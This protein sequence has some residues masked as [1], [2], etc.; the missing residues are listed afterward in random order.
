MC[1]PTERS[2]WM[3]IPDEPTHLTQLVET[4]SEDQ[5]NLKTV[6]RVTVYP[7][8]SGFIESKQIVLSISEESINP[9]YIGT[10]SQRASFETAFA[11]VTKPCVVD[12]TAPATVNY[13]DTFSVGWAAAACKQYDFL[14]SGNVFEHR[15]FDGLSGNADRTVSDVAI[16]NKV[17]VGASGVNASGSSASKQKVVVAICQGTPNNSPV[18]FS[19]AVQAGQQCTT[20]TQYACNE[21]QAKKIV[22]LTKPPRDWEVKPGVCQSFDVTA[23]CNDS[24]TGAPQSAIDLAAAIGVVQRNNPTCTVIAGQCRWFNVGVTCHNQCGTIPQYSVTLEAAI[25]AQENANSTCS[26]ASACP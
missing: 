26:V 21:D 11:S 18:S 23:T 15:I 22:E 24:C 2:S 6:S 3:W 7:P 16:Y 10:G 9:K 25:K 12:V 8:A 20:V 4:V 1:M 17:I 19:F 5:S 14:A 13:F